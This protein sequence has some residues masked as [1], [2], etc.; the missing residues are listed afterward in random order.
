MQ[1]PRSRHPHNLGANGRVS[2]PWAAS[3]WGVQMPRL[4][5]RGEHGALKIGKPGAPN[6]RLARNI[7]TIWPRTGEC[8]TLWRLPLE[9][10]K[11]YACYIAVG[12]K[13]APRSRHPH[14]LA[15]N[16]RVSYP[17]AAAPCGTEA[18]ASLETSS[19]SA[20]TP[21]DSA[22]QKQANCLRHPR[23]LGPFGCW[24]QR[25]A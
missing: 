22:H 23:N 8:N 12:S 14:N 17:L 19:Q 18:S 15:A 11:C 20:L 2:Y 7:P 4:L 9:E 10:S 1:A 24:N 25:L 13:R 16:G 21:D 6:E 3:P 5:H